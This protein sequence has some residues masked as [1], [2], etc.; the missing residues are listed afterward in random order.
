MT[1]LEDRLRR[2]LRA[3]SEQITPES[4]TDLHLPGPAVRPGRPRSGGSWR[5]IR[6]AAGRR[7][8]LRP[9]LAWVKPL[10]AA[11]AVVAVIAGALAVSRA[12]QG[13]PPAAGIPPDYSGAPAY[14]AYTA[15]GP[16]YIELSNG[17]QF[18]AA[19]P[20]RYIKVRATATGN[21]VAT[22]S[23]PKPY[24][25]FSLLTAAA[26]GRT[27]VL[28]AMDNFQRRVGRSPRLAERTQRTPMVFLLLRVTPDGHTTLSTLSLPEQLTPGDVP[29][30]ALS[31]EGTR[32]ALTF[33][34]GG[35]RVVVQVI[36]LA[37]GQARMW[38]QPRARWRPLI[39]GQ[40]AWTADGRTLAVA[41]L[42]GETSG[43]GGP[44]SGQAPA[45]TRIDLL[46]TAGPGSSLASARTLVLHAPPGRSR[47][48]LLF[49]TP[50]GAQ[51]ISPVQA[52]L[53]HGGAAGEL[54]VYSARSGRLLRTMAPWHW[55]GGPPP[56]GRGGSPLQTVAW[57]DFTGHRLIVLQPHG[58]LNV[59]GVVTDGSF[60]GMGSALLPG[61]AAGYQ[62]LQYAL[63][64]ALQMTW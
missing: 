60:A 46:D 19:E 53:P 1:A 8:A 18:A 16:R 40:G 49:S 35:R 57:S 63:R 45:V 23:P 29:S 21:L 9:W 50:D 5:G 64:I 52:R 43:P 30:I 15:E 26:D 11:A 44:A 31:P 48:N 39:E 37:T 14:Y 62:E 34:Q 2:D 59:L 36:T 3:E 42:P 7:G 10:A 51:L 6:W 13:H 54:A 32:L 55:P 17:P 56:P 47:P 25:D 27:F 12:I 4:L 20:G 61:S 41:Q 22:I 33:N 24:N 28:G 58:G 38:T